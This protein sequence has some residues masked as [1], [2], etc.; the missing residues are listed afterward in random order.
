MSPGSK[1]APQYVSAVAILRGPPGRGRCL[2]LKLSAAVPMAH[3]SAPL[4]K[5]TGSGPLEC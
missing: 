3:V 5:P 1:R 4:S 2:G